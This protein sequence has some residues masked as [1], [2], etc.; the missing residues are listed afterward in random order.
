MTAARA[1]LLKWVG[2]VAMLVDHVARF[3]HVAIPGAEWVGRLAFPCFAV[4]AAVQV[5]P[6][7]RLR[8]A[9][10]LLCVAA[11]LLPLRLF[12]PGAPAVT[13]VLTLACGLLAAEG[14]EAGSLVGFALV[15]CSLLV[16][17]VGEYSIGGVLLVAGV[18]VFNSGARR[19]RE[20]AIAVACSGAALLTARA[21]VAGAPMTAAALI[22]V[23]AYAL[24]GGVTCP[25]V[26]G[27][28]LP[29]Y[30]GQW[31]LVGVGVALFSRR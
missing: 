17:Y 29:A 10:R 20:F 5:R 31:V 11:L 12:V 4:A 15:A 22:L 9:D 1:E 6:C 3:F 25:R 19:F 16:G 27:F 26:K 13:V 8:V 2:L 7:D 30:V 21:G 14:V 23:L 18:A 24:A 28:F